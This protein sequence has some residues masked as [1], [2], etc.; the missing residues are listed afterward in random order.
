MPGLA[1]SL[2]IQESAKLLATL[3]DFSE[4]M[5]QCA[6]LQVLVMQGKDP[7]TIMFWFGSIA[8]GPNKFTIV[9]LVL[10]ELADS[11]QAAKRAIGVERAIREITNFQPTRP[12]ELAA[13]A[14]LIQEKLTL[15][16]VSDLPHFLST[17]LAQMVAKSVEVAAAAK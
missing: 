15:K 9:C 14:K 2:L 1:K 3:N 8:V 7:S 4:M 11:R 10:E 6:T 17:C 12:S 16:G 13:R 5:A